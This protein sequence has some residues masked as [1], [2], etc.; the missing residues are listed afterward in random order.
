[1]AYIS[2]YKQPWKINFD[3]VTLPRLVWLIFALIWKLFYR[4]L[5]LMHQYWTRY[6]GYAVLL[7]KAKYWY[8]K[9]FKQGHAS[10]EFFLKQIN[11]KTANDKKTDGDRQH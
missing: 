2:K 5:A 3:F 1:L 10:A 9:A 6:S 11:D 4:F 7:R 8:N